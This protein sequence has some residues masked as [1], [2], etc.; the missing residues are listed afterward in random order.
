M[1]GLNSGGGFLR[2]FLSLLLLLFLLKE[3]RVLCEDLGAPEALLGCISVVFVCISTVLAISCKKKIIN[4]RGSTGPQAFCNVL[5]G[6]NS[7]G[8]FLGSSCCCCCC[9][10]RVGSR[11]WNWEHQKLFWGAFG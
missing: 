8:G 10:E 5:K 2:F 9:K 6:L 4:V 3:G 11:G 7:G 1:E